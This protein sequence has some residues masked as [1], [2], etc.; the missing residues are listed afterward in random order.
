M[1]ENS[2]I[3]FPNFSTLVFLTIFFFFVTCRSAKKYAYENLITREMQFEKP[4]D[5]DDDDDEED[6]D[7]QDVNPVLEKTSPNNGVGPVPPPS[8]PP[9][10]PPPPEEVSKPPLPPEIPP[11]PPTKPPPESQVEDMDLSDEE[12]TEMVPIETSGGAGNSVKPQT[13][14][15]SGGR[16]R[17]DLTDALS[18]FY[19]DLATINADSGDNTDRSLDGAATISQEA[20][21]T[22]P[23][24]ESPGPSS[25]GGYENSPNVSDNERSNSPFNNGETNEDRPKRKSTTMRSTGLSMKKKNVGSLVAKWQN[26]QQ[27]VKRN[28]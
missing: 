21:P 7:V 13:E 17:V 23:N 6:E 22:P 8:Q 2:L 18:S 10:P 28:K 15:T 4:L 24:I 12:E 1:V 14:D 26:I 27:E 3:S 9:L 11:P 16:G 5:E 19:S 25:V 20:T